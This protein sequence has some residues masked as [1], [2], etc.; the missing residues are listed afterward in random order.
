LAF[1][2]FG[3]FCLRSRGVTLN[4][5]RPRSNSWDAAAADRDDPTIR[6]CT[7][8]ALVWL[9]FGRLDVHATAGCQG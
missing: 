8:A 4:S 9:Y 5:C 7:L 1:G 6:A 3:T 2:T